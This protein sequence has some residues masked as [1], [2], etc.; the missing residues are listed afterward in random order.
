MSMKRRAK[1]GAGMRM[2]A[3][4]RKLRS[5][6]EIRGLY[7]HMYKLPDIS[8]CDMRWGRHVRRPRFYD[9]LIAGGRV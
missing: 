5:S 3:G 4:F 2:T 6:E 9:G 1:H 7:A 8:L